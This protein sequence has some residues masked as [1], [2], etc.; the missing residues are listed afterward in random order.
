MAASVGIPP[1]QDE[2]SSRTDSWTGCEVRP[3]GFEPA[4]CGLGNRRSIHLSYGRIG[5]DFDPR[6]SPRVRGVLR[7]WPSGGILSIARTTGESVHGS[8][9]MSGEGRVA[10]VTG[11]GQRDRPGDRA[12][13]LRILGFLVVVNYRNDR[14]AAEETC[15]AAERRGAPRA[16]AI[17]ADVADL[18]Q[19]RHLIGAV[20]DATGRIDLWVNNA[21]VAP[22]SRRDLLETT[23]ES[24]DHVLGVNLRGPFF[25]TQTVARALLIWSNAKSSTS[26][27]SCLSHR[28]R[29][30]SRASIAGSIV[31]RKPV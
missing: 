30:R 4:T 16:F 3:V 20:L 11:G 29:A 2:D 18:E 1:L 27:G 17:Q 24:W 8:D 28:F 22:A 23:T 31:S 6:R 9:A 10:V 14:A 13:R 15:R 25:L 5:P 21:G 19:G 26:R 7:F 12:L